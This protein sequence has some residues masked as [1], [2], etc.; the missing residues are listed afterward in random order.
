MDLEQIETEGEDAFY[1]RIQK[2]RDPLTSFY[3]YMG[4]KKAVR[5]L[6]EKEP[7]QNYHAALLYFENLEQYVEEY[8][9]AFVV[10]MM[11]NQAMFLRKY[12]NDLQVPYVIARIKKNIFFFFWSCEDEAESEHQL[13]EIY[14][15]LAGG[16]FGR[17]EYLKPGLYLG[18]KHPKL[19][20]DSYE[21]MLAHTLAAAEA[22]KKAECRI[23]RYDP[24]MGY[25]QLELEGEDLTVR[26][27]EN[28][29]AYFDRQF[30]SFVVS[31]LSNAKDLDSSTDMVIQRIGSKFEFDDVLVSE[32]IGKTATKVTNRWMR[33][34]GIIINDSDVNTF[35]DWDGFFWG[36]DENGINYVTDVEKVPFSGHDMEFFRMKNIGSFINIL[37]YNNDQSIGYITCSKRQPMEKLE[38]KTLNSLIQF[39][40]IIASF[41]ALRIHKKSSHSKIEALSV[42]ELTGLYQYAAFQ[43][44]VKKRLYQYT[45]EKVYAFVSLDISNFSHLNENFGYNEGDRVLKEFA[46]CIKGSGEKINLACRQDAD[47][48]ILLMED[49]DKEAI[50]RRIQ[51]NNEN[52]EAYLKKLYPMSGL[53]VNAGVYYVSDPGK[54]LF[55]MIDSAAHA[56]KSVKGSYYRNIA[57]YSDE[58]RTR[59]KQVLN[60]VGTIH[61]AIEG[62]EIETFLQ[63]KFSMTSRKVVGAEA[64]VRWRN[65]DGSYK[66]PDQFIPILE[67]AG[68]IVNLDM[69]VF[70]QVLRALARWKSEGKELVPVSV[71]FSRIHFRTNDFYE[72]VVTLMQQYQIEPK[73]IE[74][75]ITESSFGDNRENLYNQLEKVREYGFKVDIDDFGTGYSSLNMLL[76]A[77]VD[78]VK[79]DKSFIDHYETKE[80]QEYINQIGNL[81]ISAK[82]GIIF[83]GVE[84]EEQIEFLTSYGYDN[85]QGYFFSRPIPIVEFERNFL[86]A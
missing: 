15:T 25:G 41:V 73:Y 58:L 36:F 55:Y 68:L 74:I 33:E 37:L 52:F 76:S 65:P 86:T 28:Q 43:R 62:G 4:A 7:E 50:A 32:F 34:K 6:L 45:P 13:Q 8:G 80:Q 84:T 44:K 30:I 63:P 64:L 1:E 21:E 46:M 18:F 75:E 48:F 59:K 78:I 82:K 17:S 20:E 12:Y 23:T 85:A 61:E 69:C 71:N 79:V 42:D 2:R 77:P 35:E 83:E 49:T 57:I 5:S 16:Y 39:S 47:H 67:G 38:D 70:E 26:Q 10:A 54:N 29:M 31:L 22:G 27:L 53:Q 14:D 51:E 19:G 56:R 81:I 9:S 72:K 66:F 11:E 24:K 60:V 3:N 40:K